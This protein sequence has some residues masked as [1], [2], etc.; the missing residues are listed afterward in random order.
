[1]QMFFVPVG[2]CVNAYDVHVTV[3]RDKFLIIEPTSFIGSWY[4]ASRINIKQ[5]QHD[6]AGQ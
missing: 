6:A 2:I 3:Y 4:R 1:M 5:N